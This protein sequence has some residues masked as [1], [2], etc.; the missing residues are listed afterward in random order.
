MSWLAGR[1]MARPTFASADA[2]VP[3]GP[4]RETRHL[5][6][7]SVP[8]FHIWTTHA[9]TLEGSFLLL[10]LPDAHSQVPARVSFFQ[11]NLPPAS[12]FFL[13][14]CPRESLLPRRLFSSCGARG[15]PWF[16]AALG[17]GFSF[18]R[19]WAL[20]ALE[21]PCLLRVGSAVQSA[22]SRAQAP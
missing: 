14:F 13:S 8:C 15:L 6:L 21:R 18:C 7:L 16:L 9:V 12:S 1:H 11:G 4:A 22:S 17:G 3:D 2:S 20:G 5:G 10:H 19:A